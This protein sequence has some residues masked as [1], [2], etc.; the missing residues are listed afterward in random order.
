M[1]SEYL[2]E[3]AETCQTDT[4]QAIV[5][6]LRK[7]QEGLY[8][9]NWIRST[10]YR[11]IGEPKTMIISRA[12]RMRHQKHRQSAGGWRLARQNTVRRCAS[13]YPVEHGSTRRCNCALTKS[14]S[15]MDKWNCWGRAGGFA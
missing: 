5:A 4:V 9:M 11:R 6:T 7:L 8:A 10:S 14:F 3:K 12:G 13:S 15:R 2:N 1:M